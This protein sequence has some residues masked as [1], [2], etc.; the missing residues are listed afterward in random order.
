MKTDLTGSKAIVLFLATLVCVSSCTKKNEVSDSTETSGHVTFINASPGLVTQDFFVDNIKVNNQPLAYTQSTGYLEIKAAG[1]QLQVKS[2]VNSTL[3]NTSTFSVTAPFY[4]SIFYAEDKLVLELED[5]RT[6]PKAGQC[7]VRFINLS[8]IIG[9]VDIGIAK[10]IKF[11]SG[12]DYRTYSA[13]YDF[14]AGTA[15]TL[16]TGGSNVIIKDIAVTLEAGH[17]YTIYLTGSSSSGVKA[18]LLTLD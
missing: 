14:N 10:G 8:S 4:Y 11:L 7:R 3:N 2:S 13:Y 9:T 15:F 17:L 5:E 16:Y 18:Q 6:A 1:H 12:L